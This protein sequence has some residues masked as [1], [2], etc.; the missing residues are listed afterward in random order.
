[1]NELLLGKDR[2]KVAQL[3]ELSRQGAIPRSQAEDAERIMIQNRQQLQ[4]NQADIEQAKGE[5]QKQ[6]GVYQRILR[7]GELSILD[8]T[9]QIRELQSQIADAKSEIQQNQAI[10]KSLQY[11]RRQRIL[12]APASGTLFQLLV[13]HPGAVVQAGQ[14]IAQIS[15]QTARLVLRGRMNNKDTGF[16]KIGLPAQVKF[17]AYPF[18][19]YGVLKGRLSWISPTSSQPDGGGSSTPP[20]SSPSLM[21]SSFEVEIELERPSLLAPGQAIALK[22]GQ[23]ATAEIVVRQR[24]VLDLFLDPFQKLGKTGLKL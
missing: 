5:L 24:R 3:S 8:K 21:N 2:D 11:Q 9:K 16:L 4:K 10:I 22:A 12:Y 13:Q 14:T 20:S 7:D 19:D 18:Q 17:D 15:P 6:Q 1:L 23:T